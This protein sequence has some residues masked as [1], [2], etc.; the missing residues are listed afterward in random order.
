MKIHE[1]TKYEI[2]RVH[3]VNR[4]VS[5]TSALEQSMRK[6]GFISA[7]PVHVIKTADGKLE[8]KAGHHRYE[9]ASRL[10]IPVKYVI[11]AD[12]A[13]IHELEKATNPWTMKDY[14]DSFCRDKNPHYQELKDLV[15]ETG[16]RVSQGASLLR[17][18]LA[19][20]N[21]CRD[22]FKAGAFM[23][24]TRE[25]ADRVRKIVL[26]AKR[27]N[28]DCA[29]NQYFINALSKMLF[30]P[31][32]EDAVFIQKI[33][34]H[35]HMFSRKAT[36]AEYEQLIEDVYNRQ[37]KNKISL[38]FLARSASMSRQATFGNTRRVQN[39]LEPIHIRRAASA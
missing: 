22:Q 16:L 31:E 35:A 2:F 38:A 7:Y 3:P 12:S 23:V 20:S 6:H 18:E 13:S 25:L 32:F 14:L 33:K 9:V 28:I 8:I 34:S 24:K 27:Y 30:V 21:N 26:V 1:T 37:N 36:L 19:S 15:E 4:R 11:C 29:T 10:G 39:N 17:G 5:K